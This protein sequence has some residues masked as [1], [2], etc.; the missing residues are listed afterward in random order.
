[1][2]DHLL[3]LVLV[4]VQLSRHNF[5]QNVMNFLLK[6]YFRIFQNF[7]ALNAFSANVFIKRYITLTF[8][9]ASEIQKKPITKTWTV[10]D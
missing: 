5:D 7:I 10:H 2:A 8:Y 6:F 9:T 3:C 4:S 1:M